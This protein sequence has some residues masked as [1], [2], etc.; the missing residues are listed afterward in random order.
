MCCLSEKGRPECCCLEQLGWQPA[1]VSVAAPSL[2][3][4][5]SVARAVAEWAWPGPDISSQSVD[6]SWPHLVTGILLKTRLSQSQSRNYVGNFTNRFAFRKQ[7]Q[8]DFQLYRGSPD[9][10]GEEK[11]DT[12]PDWTRENWIWINWQRLSGR[13]R[14]NVQVSMTWRRRRETIQY[15]HQST[16]PVVVRLGRPGLARP[17]WA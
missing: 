16:A 10:L 3:S 2:S 6:S 13:E 7:S 5:L 1:A 12:R 11:W 17:S 8:C 4:L 14:L 15:L 9:E